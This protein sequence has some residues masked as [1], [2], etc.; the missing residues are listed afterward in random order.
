MNKSKQNN[1][2]HQS[3]EDNQI[4][5]QNGYKILTNNHQVKNRR[6][7]TGY[8]FQRELNQKGK[9]KSNLSRLMVPRHLEWKIK[10]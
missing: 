1:L 7:N 9:V 4:I 5:L 3:E 8:K 6:W 10:I 2:Q